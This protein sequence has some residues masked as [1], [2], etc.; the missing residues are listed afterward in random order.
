MTSTS[1]ENAPTRFDA[2]ISRFDEENSKDPN[3]HQASG[4]LQPFELVYSKWL[5]QWLLRLEPQAS[6]PLRLAARCQHLCRWQIPRDSYPMTRVGYLQWREALKKFHAQKSG[7]I[8]RAAGYEQDIIGRV[9]ELVLKK[10]FPNDPE[11]R[12]LEDALCLV[13]LELQFASLAAKTSDDKL[14]S[15][16][17]KT[18]KKMTSRAQELVLKLPYSQHEKELLDRALSSVSSPQK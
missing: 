3:Q 11:G 18:W 7:E 9:Q 4:T 5:T 16:L 12:V 2:A 10:N 17:Q 14:I 8:L 1:S 6:E 13:F 15:V